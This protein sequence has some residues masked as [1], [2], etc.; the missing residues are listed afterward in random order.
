MELLKNPFFQ[1]LL[2][3]HFQCL[4]CPKDFYQRS[5]QADF[6]QIDSQLRLT[7]LALEENSLDT[8]QKYLADILKR[9][10][11]M[12]DKFRAS[13]RALYFYYQDIHIC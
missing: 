5:I 12:P 6:N 9:F 1:A 10:E 11:V 8:A 2:S 3:C 7:R 13:D 4:H